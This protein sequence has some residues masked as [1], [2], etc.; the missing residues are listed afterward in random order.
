MA[1][2]YGWKFPQIKGTPSPVQ[3]PPIQAPLQQ[4]QA[5]QSILGGLIS[6]FP[7]PRMDQWTTKE[8]ARLILPPLTTKG[9]LEKE[10]ALAL[11]EPGAARLAAERGLDL[12]PS[13]E[14]VEVTKRFEEAE[15]RR[16]QHEK[17]VE[18]R[19]IRSLAA[20]EERQLKTL[21]RQEARDIMKSGKIRGKK[22]TWE[23]AYSIAENIHR[24]GLPP[25]DLEYEDVEKTP[26]DILEYR[27][28]SKDPRFKGKTYASFLEWKAATTR[29]PK[30]PKAPLGLTEE[31]KIRDDAHRYAEAEV[32]RTVPGGFIFD[33]ATGTYKFEPKDPTRAN[34][35]YTEAYKRYFEEQRKRAKLYRVD[36]PPLGAEDV[37]APYVEESPKPA[38]SHVPLKAIPPVKSKEREDPLG[39]RVP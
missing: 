11:Q 16:I 25:T 34:K 4:P 38:P 37:V 23:E 36:I 26:T 27:E 8:Q 7:A 39:I 33:S 20:Q 19:Q 5:T 32:R 2:A 12:A 31:N 17:E 3:A 30:E 24:Y 6:D 28:W 18:E 35:I 15:E 9:M 10:K 21:I 29:A 22:P 13:A 1:K 14:S